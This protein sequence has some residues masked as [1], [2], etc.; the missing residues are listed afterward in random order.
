MMVIMMALLVL[1]LESFKHA[2]FL[3]RTETGILH[4]ACQD[5][6][7]SQIFQLIVSASE[8]TLNSINVVVWR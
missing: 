6:G 5:S 2:A 4:F 3:R 8:K 7:L 1:T